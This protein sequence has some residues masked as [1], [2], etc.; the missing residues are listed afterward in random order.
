[1]RPA[2][3]NM[4]FDTDEEITPYS[5]RF[6]NSPM[7]KLPIAANDNHPDRVTRMVAYNGGS[8][9]LSHMTPV[10]LPRLACLGQKRQV[11]A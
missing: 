3:T 8:S 1:M 7:R 10:T 5:W 4:S 9:G 2:R 11:A 6:T